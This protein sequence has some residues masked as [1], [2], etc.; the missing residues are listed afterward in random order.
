MSAHSGSNKSESLAIASLIIGLV[1]LI[2]WGGFG[3]GPII[4]IVLGALA[5]SRVKKN[6]NQYERRGIAIAGITIS[7]LVLVLGIIAGIAIPTPR[8]AV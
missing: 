8:R 2:T 3:I 5:L 7:V 1:S 6:P 4:S